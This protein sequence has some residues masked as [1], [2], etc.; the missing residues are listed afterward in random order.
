MTADLAIRPLTPD[1]GR[2]NPCAVALT[3]RDG[4]GCLS[5]YRT[6]T[7]TSPGAPACNQ[8]EAPEPPLALGP[9]GLAGAP[10]M[11]DSF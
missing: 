5:F 7:A 9:R 2:D 11:L 3:V 4:T 1:L 10:Y 8:G 6:G